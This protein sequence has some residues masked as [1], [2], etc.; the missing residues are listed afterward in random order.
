MNRK[1]EKKLTLSKN[2]KLAGVCGGLAEY[3]D[4]DPTLVRIIYALLTFSTAFCGIL[5]YP[6]LWLIMPEPEEIQQ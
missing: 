3:F 5:L 1:M 2:K 6:V 4:A